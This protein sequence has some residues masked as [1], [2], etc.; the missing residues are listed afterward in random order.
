MTLANRHEQSR[1]QGPMETTPGLIITESA[2]IFTSLFS[3]HA[4]GST[5]RGS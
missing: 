1:T 2:R 3:S 5:P 4:T